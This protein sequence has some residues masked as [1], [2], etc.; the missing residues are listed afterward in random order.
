MKTSDSIANIAT[1]M[2]K[3][4]GS[5]SD[6]VKDTNNDFGGYRYATL[7]QLVGMLRPILTTNGLMVSQELVSLDGGV[8]TVTRVLHV[9][10]EWIETEPLAMSVQDRKG[11]TLAQ[12]VGSTFT[13]GRR[14]A[15][16]ALFGIAAEAD[17]DA[18]DAGK[19]DPRKGAAQYG[20]D[21]AQYDPRTPAAIARRAQV[22]AM[23]EGLRPKYPRR[24]DPNHGIDEAKDDFAPDFI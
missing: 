13:Y 18:S 15:L 1:A 22:D 4:A 23:K 8:G 20:K 21:A 17:D 7:D 3:A 14:Y 24:G 9:S 12:A 10:G 5:A 16:Q 6:I 2:V 11:M 19:T